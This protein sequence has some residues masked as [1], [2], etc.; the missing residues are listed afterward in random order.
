[1]KTY[2]EPPHEVLVSIT[3]TDSLVA[4]PPQHNDIKYCP[5]CGKKLPKDNSLKDCN[6]GIG[7]WDELTKIG[8]N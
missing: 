4:I 2:F 7:D 6:Y 8:M 1:M 3:N 5:Y